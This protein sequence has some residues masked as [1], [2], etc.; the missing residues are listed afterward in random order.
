MKA[1]KKEYEQAQLI[2]YFLTSGIIK[3][4]LAYNLRSDK[5]DIYLEDLI[6]LPEYQNNGH[7]AARLLC[8]FFKEIEKSNLS[9]TRTYT[10]KLNTKMQG[11]LTKAGF[12]IDEFTDKGIKYITSKEQLM[13]RCSNLRKR[14]DSI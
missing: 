14:Y 10:N 9:L 7:T 12:S 1:M 2:F 4:Y 3:G 5:Q 8:A 13:E 11:I 6:I